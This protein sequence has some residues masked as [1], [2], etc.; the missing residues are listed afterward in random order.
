MSTPVSDSF[1]A[2]L[3][4][5]TL[6][7]PLPSEAWSASELANMDR[8]EGSDLPECILK[9]TIQGRERTVRTIME[10][11][12]PVPILFEVNPD[13][14][15]DQTLN[16]ISVEVDHSEFA[17]KAKSPAAIKAILALID[18]F[19]MKGLM[20]TGPVAPWL[21][22]GSEFNPF[23]MRHN[24]SEFTGVLPALIDGVLAQPE[25]AIALRAESSKT[26][27]PEA[28]KPMLCWASQ[29]MLEQ[30]PNNLAPLEHVQEVIGFGS[31]KDWREACGQPG[32]LD[33]SKIEVGIQ[34][35]QS[36]S[37]VVPY[38]QQCMTPQAS[39]YGFE[40]DQGRHLCETTADFLLQFPALDCDDDNLKAAFTFTANYC[41]IDIM[42]V[43]AIAVCREQFGVYQSRDFLIPTQ[44]ET[45]EHSFDFLF[46]ALGDTHPLHERVRNLMTRD[47]WVHLFKKA[48]NVSPESMV[49][50]YQAFGVDNTGAGLSLNASD[51]EVLVAGGYQF[52]SQTINHSDSRFFDDHVLNGDL[53][54]RPSVFLI[55]TAGMML[56]SIGAIQKYREVYRN[57]LRTNLWPTSDKPPNDISQ[58]LKLSLGY[59]LKN[60]V[61]HQALALNAYFLNAGVE[62][63]AAAVR[64]PR[65]WMTLAHVFSAQELKPYLAE[66]PL[67]AK[68][69]VLEDG[70]GL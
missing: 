37:E 25:L 15:F 26:S 58:A 5:L 52:S 32:A 60:P 30:F 38:L 4:L 18:E 57:I 46:S 67:D 36:C 2:K 47:Q 24:V 29:S 39:K 34:A 40:D 1:T 21:L 11:R 19:Q 49:G 45:M 64:S 53:N 13:D 35:T 23:L 65:H 59:S 61:K 62:A 51:F 43:Q 42:A 54:S 14:P 22:N 50:L 7:E 33:F 16:G 41:P 68:G 8:L 44:K 27:T 28:Y 48:S 9:A 63:C 10:R 31:M 17:S 12:G 20:E 6:P 56:G 55:F 69:R 70:L 3:C 66:M